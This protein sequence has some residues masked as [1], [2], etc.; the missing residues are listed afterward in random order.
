M[1]QYLVKDYMTTHPHWIRKEATLGEAMEM[2]SKHRIRHLPVKSEDKVIGIV[3]ER[4]IKLVLWMPGKDQD[5]TQLSSFC[6]DD[7]FTVE[8]QT[9]LAEAAKK[10]A[11]IHYGS[12]IVMEGNTL[13][14]IFTTV[15]ACR[16]LAEIA[17]T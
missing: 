5:K 11:D 13:V 17:G 4:D 10:M 7:P 8:P 1:R 12:A 6:R 9:P 15:D 14:G 16:A 3:S 2:M